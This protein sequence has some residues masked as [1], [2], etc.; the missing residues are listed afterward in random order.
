M[1]RLYA[2]DVA[3]FTRKYRFTGGRMRRVKL[4]YAT[5]ENF[6]VEFVLTASIAAKDLGSQPKPVKLRFRITG[7]E[8]FRFQKRPTMRSGSVT[9]ARIGWFQDRFFINLDAWGLLPGDV[10][11]VHDYRASDTYVAGRDLYWEEVVPKPKPDA[12]SEKK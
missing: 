2:T 12:G 5:T 1:N 4:K 6:T 8:E 11:K 10:P 3:S 9:E 7:V